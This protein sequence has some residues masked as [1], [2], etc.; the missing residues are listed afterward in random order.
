MPSPSAA[1]VCRSAHATS[2]WR[3]RTRSGFAAAFVR[4]ARLFFLLILSS[5]L[6]ALAVGRCYDFSQKVVT[7]RRALPPDALGRELQRAGTSS[8]GF[9]WAEVRGEVKKPIRKVLE[10][11]IDH[12]NTRADSDE[13]IATP[14]K[15]E[16]YL[17]LQEVK[18]RTSP[19]PLLTLRWT[20]EW[21][22]AL[23]RGTPA[24][25]EEIVVSYE[26]T[27]G[28][29]FIEHMC[30]SIVVRRTGETTT[31]VFWFE[32]AKIPHRSA[33]DTRDTIASI[34]KVLRDK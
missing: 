4:L 34:L 7:P 12:E 2:H 5:S 24:E 11:L 25:P 15:S 31:E 26:K 6:P 8:S 23:S 32:E 20:E 28:T 33:E 13:A 22:F 19:I 10:L 17:A 16:A 9:I 1:A 29:S 18:F 3:S 14:V 30:G 27:E 21:A